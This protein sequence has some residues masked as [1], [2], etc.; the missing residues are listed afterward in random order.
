MGRDVRSFVSSV[1]VGAAGFFVVT[2][3]DNHANGNLDLTIE[4]SALEVS[5]NLCVPVA[6]PSFFCAAAGE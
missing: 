6:S 1:N 4:P 3:G 2:V 5:S